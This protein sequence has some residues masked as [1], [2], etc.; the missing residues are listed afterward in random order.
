MAAVV[1]VRSTC[2][3]RAI[4][5]E[6]T[7]FWTSFTS[8]RQRLSDTI[9]KVRDMGEDQEREIRAR[10]SWE[11]GA[12]VTSFAKYVCRFQWVTYFL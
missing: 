12:S 6:G 10:E 7:K 5:S 8:H 3:L 2:R 9:Q 4:E 11:G 1:V